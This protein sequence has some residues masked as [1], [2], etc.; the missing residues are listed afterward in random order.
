MDLGT[1]EVSG[2]HA[3]GDS[4]L[5]FENII[6][7][8]YADA[9]SG[10]DGDNVIEGN[11]GADTLDGG[12]GADTV[13]YAG[14]DAGVWV[15][16]RTGTVFGGHAA[17]DTIRGFEHIIGSRH[18]DILTGDA[19]SNVIA[20]GYGNDW[21]EG[22]GGADT[23]DGGDGND[24][25]SYAGSD[26]P[27]T[28]NLR[29]N[30]VSGGHAEG[31]NIRGFEGISGSDHA[32]TLTGDDGDNF[33]QGGADADILDG[34][35]GADVVS[36]AGSYYEGVTVNLL[37]GEASGGHAEGDS[38]RGFEHIIG[39]DHADMLSGDDGDN[40]IAGFDGADTLDGGAG[41]DRAGGRRWRRHPGR[42]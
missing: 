38:I 26:A 28:V 29:T 16:L 11:G 12:D 42:R 37:T 8:N 20:A 25:V 41:N 10:D 39:S 2:A 34:G 5:N 35:G 14:S 7:S 21:V 31:D 30:Q 32:D 24:I 18:A 17:G 19:G 1:G 33:I 9:L 3:T 13:S 23:L 27:V 6:G 22:D 15:N 4:I 40:G 36:Y